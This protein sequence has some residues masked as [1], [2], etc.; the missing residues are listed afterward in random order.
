MAFIVDLHT[1][2]ISSGHAYSTLMD[3]V[4]YAKEHAISAFGISD[5]GPAMPGGPNVFHIA[6]QTVIPRYIDDV[7]ILRGVEANIINFNGDIDI[8]EK[9]LDR[10][11]YAIASLHDVVLKP[12]TVEQ[13]TSA[14]C[15]A[16][17]KSKVRILGH[18]GNPKFPLDY[19]AIVRAC[20]DKNIAIEIN[21][22]TFVSGS[23]S[24]SEEHCMMLAKLCYENNIPIILGSDAHIHFDLAEFSQCYQLLDRASIP[25][26]YP[27]NYRRDQ[28]FNWL[29][30][31]GLE[32]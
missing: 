10:L 17:E 23:R 26:D 30:V 6:N 14:V 3:Y 24:G 20:K 9:F 16:I 31:E 11:D 2:T 19:A 18:L 4:N 29:G 21:N 25:R 27:I 12:G 1:H 13:N 8:E 22:S 7:L 15:G 5:H 28:F 32:V